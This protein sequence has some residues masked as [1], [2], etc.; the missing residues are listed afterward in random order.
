MHFIWKPEYKFDIKEI[1][2]QHQYFVGIMDKLYDAIINN[3]PRE[4]LGQLLKELINYAVDHF[5]TEE[6]Y[7]TEFN[8]EGTED[9]KAKH[10]ELKDKVLD[11]QKKFEDNSSDISVDLIDFLEDWLVDHLLNLDQKYVDCFHQ[12]GLN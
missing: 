4:E 7:F 2:D 11:F 6:K 8:Y 9:H 10:Q 5:N 1:D 12:H 3:L